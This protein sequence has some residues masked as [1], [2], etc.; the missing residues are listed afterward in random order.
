MSK[1]ATLS[2]FSGF[3][4][5]LCADNV[6][7]DLINL[8]TQLFCPVFT[9]AAGPSSSFTT[10]ELAAGGEPCVEPAISLHSHHV[11]LDYLFASR[12]EGPGFKSLRGYLSVTGTLLLALSGYSI[13]NKLLYIFL[14]INLKPNF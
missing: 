1:P 3:Y 10:T 7:A 9:L 4:T 14:L 11:S 13:I 2:P 6:Y 5:R 12:H 8:I